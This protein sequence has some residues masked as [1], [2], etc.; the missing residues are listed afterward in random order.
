MLNIPLLMSSPGSFDSIISW[1]AGN[2][3]SSHSVRLFVCSSLGLL[4][5]LS[6]S[7]SN[8]WLNALWHKVPLTKRDSQCALQAKNV[9]NFMQNANAFRTTPL[10]SDGW[11]MDGNASKVLVGLMV[12]PGVELMM[13]C[14]GFAAKRGAIWK[15]WGIALGWAFES[16]NCD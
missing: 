3:L 7:N 12:W 9:A 11:Q 10:T 5:S 8:D 6:F 4:A 1:P 2:R 15:V 13:G 14:G 16:L